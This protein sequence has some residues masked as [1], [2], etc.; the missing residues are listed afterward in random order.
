ML[1][2]TDTSSQPAANMPLPRQSGGAKPMA[3]RMPSRRSQR[4]P[5]ASP[6][7]ES[8]SGEVTSI[9]R[10]SGSVGSLRRRA[11]GEA[12]GAPGP[13]EDDL[14]ALLLGQLGGGEGQGGVGEDAGDQE[15]L[16]VEESHWAS[17]VMRR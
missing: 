13:R 3:W 1:N 6:A 5:R 10:T 12:E 17:E 15:P 11:P 2:A 8:C 7:A 4:A 16:A 9:S 14:G